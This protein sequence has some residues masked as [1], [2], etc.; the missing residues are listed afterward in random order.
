MRGLTI[1]LTII[2]I[3]LSMSGCT[4]ASKNT[5]FAEEAKFYLNPIPLANSEAYAKFLESPR[6]ERAKLDYLIDRV[7][8]SK[9]TTFY[10]EGSRYS[11][12]EACA[13]GYWLLWR[14]YKNGQDARGFLKDIVGYTPNQSAFIDPP[15]GPMCAAYSVLMN[16]LEL[17]EKTNGK[18]LAPIVQQTS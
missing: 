2:A 15:D 17:L 9:N 6:D 13:A 14:R 5:G 16:E 18:S 4:T 1:L 12:T 10:Y 11:W 7:R 8:E 3:T